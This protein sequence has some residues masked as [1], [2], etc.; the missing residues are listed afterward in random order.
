MEQRSRIL[1]RRTAYTLRSF[2][3][4]DS[5]AMDAISRPRVSIVSNRAYGPANTFCYCVSTRGRLGYE[6]NI[7]DRA[8]IMTR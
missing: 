4:S 6:K 3:L 2:R 7:R 1:T 8:C 5:A